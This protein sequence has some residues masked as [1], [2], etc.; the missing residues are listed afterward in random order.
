MT[1]IFLVLAYAAD[2]PEGDIADRLELSLP[3][4]ATGHLDDA[5]AGPF[6]AE[7]Q[8][9]DGR[10]RA[11][12]LLREEG[13]WALRRTSP[14]TDPE[15]APLWQVEARMLRPGELI[16]LLRPDGEALTFR[17]VNVAAE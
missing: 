1:R 2:R 11:M 7:R 14:A 16:Q 5:E 12:E 13:F 9:P 6:P 3:L 4:P 10:R 15:D 8:L 17:I